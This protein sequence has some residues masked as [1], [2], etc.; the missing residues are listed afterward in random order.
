MT[1]FKRFLDWFWNKK[2]L[3]EI[4]E[5][6]DV[7]LFELRALRESKQPRPMAAYGP[8]EPLKPLSN[9]GLYYGPD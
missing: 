3:K 2:E 8:L 1:W 6:L 4:N 9:K 7:I 5:K